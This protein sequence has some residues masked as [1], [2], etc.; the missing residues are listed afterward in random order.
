MRF[1]HCRVISDK[2]LAIGGGVLEAVLM[3]INR[4]DSGTGYHHSFIVVN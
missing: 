1:R 4:M 2:A 3:A